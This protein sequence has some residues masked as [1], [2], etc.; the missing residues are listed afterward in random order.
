M[1]MAQTRPPGS[2]AFGSVGMGV[3]VA[4]VVAMA[5]AARMRRWREPREEGWPEDRRST[6]IHLSRDLLGLVAVRDIS[7]P[8]SGVR[9]V[10]WCM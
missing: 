1:D 4:E 5:A 8:H 9:V 10:V 6:G 3:A 7:S 2:A